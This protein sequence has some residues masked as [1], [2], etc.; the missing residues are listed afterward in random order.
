MASETL[1]VQLMTFNSDCSIIDGATGVTIYFLLEDSL[2]SCL[3][4][5]NK[6]SSAYY[7][8]YLL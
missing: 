1:S 5:V 3:H 7:E 4:I 6:I 8:D 2:Q